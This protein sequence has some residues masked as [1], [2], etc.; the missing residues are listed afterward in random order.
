MIF[1]NGVIAKDRVDFLSIKENLGSDKTF[2]CAACGIKIDRDIN[3]ARNI[4]LKYFT[5]R[6]AKPPFWWM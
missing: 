3:G 6:C 2:E 4:L 1:S 5:E